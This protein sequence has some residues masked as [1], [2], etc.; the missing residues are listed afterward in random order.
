M[1][2]SI[3]FALTIDVQITEDFLE[4]G[5]CETLKA[6]VHAAAFGL[7]IVMGVYNA[8]AWLRRRERHL[9]INT[10]L[11]AALTAWEQ[12]NIAH[13]LASRRRRLDADA[14]A[15]AEAAAATAVA[16]DRVETPPSDVAA[17]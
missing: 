5:S 16:I 3:S 15:A 9:A 6:T 14:A 4:P 17:A 12:K 13:H 11:Y 8:A 7:A 1:Q 10:V 2:P